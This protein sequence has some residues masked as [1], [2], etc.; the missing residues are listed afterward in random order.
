M[1]YL[2]RRDA[3]PNAE[4]PNPFEK[5]RELKRTDAYSLA[6]T[7]STRQTRQV[8]D[9]PEIGLPKIKGPQD[10]YAFNKAPF[11]A[12][13]RKPRSFHPPPP[14][15]RATWATDSTTVPPKGSTVNQELWPERKR[16][17][18]PDESDISNG[19][20]T[21]E[22]QPKQSYSS[23]ISGQRPRKRGRLVGTTNKV[24]KPS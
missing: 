6:S 19:T 15:P 3:D 9:Q 12:P 24:A 21:T 1:E 5:R 11:A 8:G 18:I 16:A 10:Y 14:T 2:Q 4:L 17:H 20:D 7:S 22:S 13:T 23:Q